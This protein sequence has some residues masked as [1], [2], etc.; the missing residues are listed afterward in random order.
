MMLQ[1]FIEKRELIKS[2]F[3]SGENLQ[4][5]IAIKC[6]DEGVNIPSI[7]TAFILASTTNP[8]EYIQRRGRVLR[9]A[10][11]KDFAEIYDF[12]TLP[13]ALGSST[14]M[15]D[16]HK[17]LT[18][19][20]PN[21]KAHELSMTLTRP[22]LSRQVGIGLG[23]VDVIRAGKN[24]NEN[25]AVKFTDFFNCSVTDLFTPDEKKLSDLTIQ[26]LK[27]K[28]PDSLSDEQKIAKIKYLLQRMKQEGII[29]TD[30]DNKRLANWVL[31]K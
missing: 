20:T 29:A 9:L 4:A 2:E 28:L 22:E 8:K 10:K 24:V 14:Y 30:S 12:L 27:E 21:E 15:I 23:T 18:K 26:L 25:T 1:S 31:K 16:E 13:A 6:L 17:K 11:G 7:K 19:Y 5:L 3:S